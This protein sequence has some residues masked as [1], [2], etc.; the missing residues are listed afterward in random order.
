MF[1]ELTNKSLLFPTLEKKDHKL[2]GPW[3]FQEENP[4]T[5]QR[6]ELCASI[7]CSNGGTGMGEN[8]FFLPREN[9]TEKKC[10]GA[11]EMQR[12]LGINLCGGETLELNALKASRQKAI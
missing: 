10:L 9:T 1:V 5:S 6:K 3:E 12:N 7:G 8:F 11:M 2:D 4:V